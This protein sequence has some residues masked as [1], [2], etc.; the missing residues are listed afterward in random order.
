[1]KPVIYFDWDGTL[2]DSMDLCVQE[3]RMTLLKMGLP[4]LPDEVIRRCNGPTYLEAVP[5]LN[6]P[7]ERAEEYCRIRLAT[8]LEIVPT[9]NHLFD[10]AR[11]LLLALREQADLCIVSNAGEDYLHLCL[12]TFRLEGMFR[13]IAAARPDRTKTQNLAA[14]LA[15]MQPERAVMVGDRLGDITAGRENG[16]LTIAAAYGYGSEAEYA[17]ADLRAYSM[18]ELQELLLQFIRE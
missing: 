18:N 16:V 14:L 4:D 8:V 11:E 13:R 2:C 10:G 12:R 1:M 17:Q 7:P 15:D 6:I 9:V 3:N 5:I